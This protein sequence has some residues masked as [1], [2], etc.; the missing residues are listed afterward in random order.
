[1]NEK[2]ALSSSG[3]WRRIAKSSTFSSGAI[4]VVLL[5]IMLI[6][7]PNYLSP[8]NV[9]ALAKVLTVTALVGFSQMVI[10]ACN[11]LNLSIGST[12]AISAVIAGWAM[13]VAGLPWWLG[14]LMGLFVGVVCGILNGLLIYR[15]GGVGVA[16]FMTTLATASVFQGINL[17]ITSG[18]TFYG[19]DGKFDKVFLSVGNEK[20]LGLPSSIFIMLIVAILLS[21]MYRKLSIGRQMLSFG[22]NN[23]AAGLY[24]VSKFKVVL[25]ANIIAAVLASIAGIL[26][27][28]RIEAAQPNMGADWMLLSFAAPLIGGTKNSG[29]KVNVIG[30][31][32]GAFALTIINNAL[33]HLKV[34]V[35]WNELIY[36]LIILIAVTIDRVR[37][38]RK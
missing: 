22:A 7:K 35:Y 4:V 28:I 26:A 6:I 23:K 1:M 9:Y 14:V 20:I 3:I 25:S 16:F 19:P 36:G 2:A 34:D 13:S 37:Y 17:M 38:I 30:A 29:G 10:I 18:N 15:A 32:L 21:L 31:I 11:G 33:V 5:S 8:N 27:M 12:G 24:G